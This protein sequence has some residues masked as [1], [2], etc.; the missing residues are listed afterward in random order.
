M[1][2]ALYFQPKKRQKRDLSI[3]HYGF[4]IET[5]GKENTFM[6]ACIANET[7][8]Y[9]Y[10]SDEECF[11]ALIHDQK[12]ADT[13]MLATNLKFDFFGL[14]NRRLKDKGAKDIKVIE[15]NGRIYKCLIVR[16]DKKVIEFRDT[17]NYWLQGS[18]EKLGAALGT[19]K[20]KPP[21]DIGS[22]APQTDEERKGMIEYCAQDARI[23]CMWYEKFI[24]T[25]CDK[26]G[27]DP[28][29]TAASMALL[30]YRTNYF[31]QTYL[32]IASHDDW[33]DIRKAYYGGETIVF[34][35]GTCPTVCECYDINS[36]YPGSMAQKR[37]PDPKT[38]CVVPKGNMFLIEKLEGFTYVEGWM[39][40]SIYIPALPVKIFDK[41]LFPTGHIKG[42][43][44][45]VELRQALAD[46]FAIKKIGKSI[47]YD[48]TCAP[49]TSFINDFYKK[50]LQL[51]KDKD[52]MENMYK[53]ILNSSYG[54]FGFNYTEKNSV[55]T[56]AQLGDDILEE[57]DRIRPLKYD[58]F[59]LL[60]TD[61]RQQTDYSLIEW[62][63]YITAYARLHLLEFMRKHEPYLL[64]V[65][66]D[67]LYL[68]AGHDPI[69]DSKELGDFKKEKDCPPNKS[70]F[71]APKHYR[72][73]NDIKIKGVS[74][75]KKD[76]IKADQIWYQSTT[77]QPIEQKQFSSHRRVLRSQEHHKHGE[78]E[79][80]EILDVVKILNVEDKKR[81]WD[82]K[83]FD[84]NVQQDSRPI[85]LT[86]EDWRKHENKRK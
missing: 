52:P 33:S 19:P 38:R 50:R 13:C 69:V 73:D 7:E 55:L 51:K 71:I 49:F 26:Y 15:R 37:Y 14:L 74:I 31:S 20:L 41:L 36:S 56:I 39:P 80:N 58:F 22:R 65:D 4:D 10:W 32:P 66:T 40:D 62:A 25:M 43:Y 23:S 28:P 82:K 53:I 54:K 30:I 61:C 16:P 34:K 1:I 42:F 59:S 21:Y 81:N 18:V 17:S 45:H 6:L 47:Y 48:K 57:C 35:R 27:V 46:G 84:I 3:R 29:Y 75:P 2:K 5:Y 9:S 76:Q 77:G 86:L 11:H 85:S 67:S 79:F 24:L 60:N 64:Y 83:K 63:A 70:I 12:F 68:M 8:T 78:L 72:F 44:T